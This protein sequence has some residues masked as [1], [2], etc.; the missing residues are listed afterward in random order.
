M[1]VLVILCNNFEVVNIVYNIVFGDRNILND[2]VGYLKKKL[3]E[4]D[5]KIVDVLIIYGEIR[6]GDIL[7]L[8]VSI[9]RVKSL[10]GYNLKYLLEEG[11]KEVVGWYWNNLK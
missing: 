5:L 4:F 8:L 9:N 11:L 7:Y 6:I 2:L 1:N 3:I 10:L